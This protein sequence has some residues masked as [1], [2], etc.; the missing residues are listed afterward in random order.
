MR[1]TIFKFRGNLATPPRV[2]NLAV[3]GPLSNA[4]P[5]LAADLLGVDC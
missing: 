5:A 3:A 4:L 1:G 2:D